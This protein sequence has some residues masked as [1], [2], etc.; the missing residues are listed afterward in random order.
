MTKSFSF[1]AP[2]G[3]HD[4]NRGPGFS[5]VPIGDKMPPAHVL[6]KH[7]VIHIPHFL[8]I[9]TSTATHVPIIQELDF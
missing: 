2:V 5:L 9:R 1:D 7:I 4:Q 3:E 6:D 8:V